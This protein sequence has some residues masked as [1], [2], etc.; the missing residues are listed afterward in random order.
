MSP[1][2][3][4]NQSDHCRRPTG[5]AMRSRRRYAGAA[6]LAVG[7]VLPLLTAPPSGAAVPQARDTTTAQTAATA[8]QVT[9]HIAAVP[10]SPCVDPDHGNPSI[11][12]IAV[13]P[14]T[15]DVRTR[16]A[17]L[18]ISATAT[19]TGGPG[20][21]RGV[22]AVSVRFMGVS[23]I[24]ARGAEFQDPDA[25]T[26]TRQPDGSWL[27]SALVAPGARAGR[28]PVMEA[29]VS[30]GHSTV[31]YGRD[32][33]LP[34]PLRTTAAEV[35]LRSRPDSKP[36]RLVSLSVH[37]S[38]VDARSGPVK[39]HVTARVRDSGTGVVAVE[40]GGELRPV[41]RRHS[42]P[43]T[44]GGPGVG[45]KGI[46]SWRG[47]FLVPQWTGGTAVSSRPI[48]VYLTDGA[49]NSTSLSGGDERTARKFPLALRVRAQV[50]HQ[51][52]RVQ[53]VKPPSPIDVR[54][55]PATAV[56]LVHAVDRGSGVRLF[57]WGYETSEKASW[58]GRLVSGTRRDGI[59][60]IAS[61]FDRCF[62]GRAYWDTMLTAE[63]YVW[64]DF[65]F[66]VPAVTIANALDIQ[67]PQPVVR[68]SVTAAGPV[69]VDFPEDVTGLTPESA[70][71]RA[72]VDDPFVLGE[73]LAGSW[74]CQTSTGANADCATAAWR[75]ALWTPAVPLAPGRYQIDINP[76]HVLS[77]TDLAGNPSWPS[78]F[79]VDG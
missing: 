54:D 15:L 65:R 24:K 21:A 60:L 44:T 55:G 13:W 49:G 72:A 51:A 28:Y 67:A 47:T 35:W 63:D 36:P 46:S 42:A 69:T 57:S 33:A 19:D 7:I 4:H 62:S 22:A 8:A 59:W 68:G 18:H 20:P 71:V 1:W 56:M 40:A 53:V 31:S 52:P 43:G 25:V 76:E 12:S 74:V 78:G 41:G 50:D 23:F 17:R 34:N 70:P 10:L 79:V 6:L 39:I 61:R 11:T 27:G 58:V 32:R 48:T 2:R 29:T 3:T 38:R 45:I 77:L 5:R 16:P 64:H 9:R 73:P 30:D 75:T 37:P 66:R 14:Q 26:L